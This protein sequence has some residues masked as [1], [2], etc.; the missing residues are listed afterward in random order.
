MILTNLTL[1][2][3]KHL[4]HVT[5]SDLVPGINVIYGP[6]KSGKSTLAEA[7]RIA[8]VDR[9]HSSNAED[10][11]ALEP[12][13]GGD[14][15]T[16][17]IGFV[18]KDASWRLAKCFS[19]NKGGGAALYESSSSEPTTRDREVTRQVASLLGVEDSGKGIGALLWPKQGDAA[20]PNVDQPLGD[21]LRQLLGVQIS[22]G[23]VEFQRVL[24]ERLKSWFTPNGKPTKEF[25]ARDEAAKEQRKAVEDLREK[26]E[27]GNRLVSEHADKKTEHAKAHQAVEQTR[28]TISDL[29]SRVRALEGRKQQIKDVKQQQNENNEKQQGV[30][31]EIEGL[32]AKSDAV[33]QAEERAAEAATSIEPL[34]LTLDARANDL[35][36]ATDDVT[37]LEQELKALETRKARIAA[38]Q[39]RQAQNNKEQE[40]AT[41]DLADL[42]RK[43]DELTQADKAFTEAAIGVEPLKKAL[44]RAEAALKEAG[45]KVTK[46]EAADK[47]LRKLEARAQVLRD[48]A[49]LETALPR[50]REALAQARA[51]EQRLANLR[52]ELAA[53]G[54]CD[55]SDK[56]RLEEVLDELRAVEAEL[57]AA[58]IAVTLVPEADTSVSIKA[59]GES[60]DE[61]LNARVPYKVPVLQEAELELTGWGTVRIKRGEAAG[62][63]SEQRTRRDK[64]RRELDA[65]RVKLALDELDQGNWVSE[66]ASRKATRQSKVGEAKQLAEDLK[67]QVPEGVEALEST[68]QREE[69][70]L[71]ERKQAAGLEQS[72][73][74][75][76]ALAALGDLSAH[77]S[78][79]NAKLERA[80]EERDAADKAGNTAAKTHLDADK[81]AQDLKG[82]ADAAR[83]LIEDTKKRTGGE[84][85]LNKRLD[86]L[87]DATRKLAEEL[88][89]EQLTEEERRLPDR[90]NDANTA[91]DNAQQQLDKSQAGHKAAVE[92]HEKAK[93]AVQAAKAVFEAEVMRTGGEV[94]LRARLNDLQ[95]AAATRN[96][97]LAKLQLTPEEERLEE[98]LRSEREALKTREKRERDISDRLRQIEGELA[99]FE[100]LHGQLAAAEQKLAGMEAA[101]DREKL[102]ADA[103]KLI[104]DWFKEERD[105]ATERSMAPVSEHVQRWLRILNNSDGAS[106][107][108][109]G[110]SLMADS[111]RLAERSV[112]LETATSYGEREQLGTLVRLAYACVLA[113]DEPQAVILDD[114]LAHSDATR[115]RRMLDVLADASKRNLQIIILTCHPERFDQLLGAK[116][117]DLEQAKTIS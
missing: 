101:R 40:A 36:L 75:A 52:Q 4:K 60:R 113:K 68:L 102:D 56:Q 42:K 2:D 3:W 13:S 95:K 103:H 94:A 45:E 76:E 111:L 107:Q 43:S 79:V 37:R 73:S 11:K 9:D 21:A 1:K 58:A 90:L 117:F 32:R 55:D 33:K 100:G 26:R 84:E 31:S 99:Q 109:S 93:S 28:R 39:Q 12:W 108:F 88:D 105:K 77:R 65:L 34:K 23:D 87:A 78:E 106:V 98:T 74:V 46:A 54:P 14:I 70:Q 114:P 80:R 47:E 91:R 59:D 48:L 67:K 19:K 51:T 63:L 92:A 64:L 41:A 110:E 61:S 116:H 44:D 83:G 81:R 6:N 35:K 66:L 53:I 5:L 30:N 89:K 38:I 96:E 17:E 49:N 50:I 86:T 69:S 97:E 18:V 57:S 27:Q 20:L 25:S 62:T 72:A 22:A 10:V 104:A 8:L 7:I 24:A 16:A 15:P 85:A 29:E 115:H 71:T 112:S 82:K